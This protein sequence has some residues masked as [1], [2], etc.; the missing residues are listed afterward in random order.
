M[1][2][3]TTLDCYCAICCCKMDGMHN[4]GKESMCCSRK[5]FQEFEWRKTL[6]ILGKTYEPQPDLRKW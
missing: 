5:C 2:F 6:A 3:F 1:G 4:Y